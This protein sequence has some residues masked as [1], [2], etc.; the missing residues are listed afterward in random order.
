MVDF[1]DL[2][3]F[4]GEEDLGGFDPIDSGKYRANLVELSRE[5]GKNSGKPY[6]KWCWK[7]SEGEPAAGRML[8]DNTSLA[9]GAKWRL[10]QV[11]KALGI[12]VPKGELKINPNELLG[13]QVVLT[14]GLELDEYANDRDGT[15]DQVR[16]VI[17]SYSPSKGSAKP[18]IELP[19]PAAKKPAKKAEP[20]VEDDWDEDETDDGVE[21]TFDGRKAQ[22]KKMSAKELK[23]LA[24]GDYD[25]DI[26]GKNRNE[27]TEA[28][29]N[30]EFPTPAEEE[31]PLPVTSIEDDDDD[32]FDFE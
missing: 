1:L 2:G 10:V 19:K 20:V 24:V 12:D 7:I 26:K 17:K 32:D 11:L 16:N 6:I 15:D 25:L 21:P 27:V 28:I 14:V 22:L 13:K 31:E 23:E 8:W 9:D 4:T 29:L 3:E 18:K 5:V 30:Y